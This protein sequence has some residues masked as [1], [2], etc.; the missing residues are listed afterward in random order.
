MTAAVVARWRATEFCIGGV[1]GG[2]KKKMETELEK[3]LQLEKT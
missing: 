1:R 2:R 3:L